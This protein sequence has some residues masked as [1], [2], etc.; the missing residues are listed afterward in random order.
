MRM[1]FR[2]SP[3]GQLIHTPV[4]DYSRFSHQHDN[5][6]WKPAVPGHACTTPQL[7]QQIVPPAVQTSL[8]PDRSPHPVF[9]RTM[10]SQAHD[11]AHHEMEHGWNID[12][13]PP[14]QRP[15]VISKKK[16]KLTIPDD[17]NLDNLD[18]LIK[19]ATSEGERERLKGE[20]QILRNR[21]AA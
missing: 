7:Q 12:C 17:R 4:H 16:G 20:K 19:H 6:E 9:A 10:Q 21:A 1:D 15:D 14:V 3:G 8:L 11:K 5:P 2:L 13:N 18:S